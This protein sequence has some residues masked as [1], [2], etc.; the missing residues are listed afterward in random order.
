MTLPS[1]LDYRERYETMPEGAS[2][3]TVSLQARNS[4]SFSNGGDELI[5]DFHQTGYLVPKSIYLRFKLS[6]VNASPSSST[7]I[8]LPFYTVFSKLQTIIDDKSV[9][10]I[11][12]YGAIQ[13]MLVNLNMNVAQ[14]YS[15]QSNLGI[16]SDPSIEFQETLF[17]L[18]NQT[19]TISLAGFIPCL[20]SNCDKLIPLQFMPK[21]SMV[22][23]TDMIENMFATSTPINS[24]SIINPELIYECVKLGSD[25]D[26]QLISMKNIFIKSQSFHNSSVLLMAGSNGNRNINFSSNFSNVKCAFIT[27]SSMITVQGAK[28]N[29][30]VDITNNSGSYSMVIDNKQYPMVELSTLNNKGGVLLELKKCVKAVFGNGDNFSINTLEFNRVDNIVQSANPQSYG[31]FILPFLF[32][33]V[34]IRGEKVGVSFQN[35]NVVININQSV[36]QTVNRLCNLNLVYSAYLEIDLKNRLV[37]VLN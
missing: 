28:L 33:N 3:H 12:P 27:F 14:K 2:T 4:L 30:A 8:I 19:T 9:D 26:K 10:T 11:S 32:E 36:S 35:K 23:T 21:I 22:F 37:K 20:L 1:S 31:K 5:F 15:N 13:T 34:N 25:F 16:S 24:I 6:I 29:D 17:V 7:Y 18:A